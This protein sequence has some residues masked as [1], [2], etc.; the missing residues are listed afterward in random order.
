MIVVSLSEFNLSKDYYHLLRTALT[1]TDEPNQGSAAPKPWVLLPGM[2]CG[3]AG[4]QAEWADTIAATWLLFYAAADLMDS[5]QDQDDPA[6]WWTEGGPA[7]AL[8]AATGLFFCASSLLSK[9]A[10]THQTKQV[11]SALSQDF[12]H[13]FLQMS[14]GQYADILYP[15]PD[16]DQYWQIASQKSGSF[17]ALACRSGARLAVQDAEIINAFGEFGQALGILIQILDDLEDLNGLQNGKAPI[18]PSL[19]SRSLPLVYALN[20][21]PKNKAQLVRQVLETHKVATQDGVRLFEI[22]E[23]SGAVL[24][25]LA[26]IDHYRSVALDKLAQAVPDETARQGLVKLTRSIGSPD[27]NSN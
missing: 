18:K 9:A 19:L 23:E 13:S 5:A 14:S 3:A 21:L 4:G 27:K 12:H 22:V 1:P 26:E 8:S 10:L 20:V 6:E 16:L 2:C 11:G 17:F 25:L 24:Y 7:V 15:Y